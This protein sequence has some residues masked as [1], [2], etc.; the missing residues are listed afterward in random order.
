MPAYI[1]DSIGCLDRQ[2][3]KEKDRIGVDSAV[4]KV[5]GRTRL[6]AVEHRPFGGIHSSKMGER[7]AV[8]IENANPGNA[9]ET[10]TQNTPA[11]ID[12]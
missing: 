12:N 10:W 7:T 6:D 8:A 1:G 5:D 2:F 9:D 3:L 11:H 4:D